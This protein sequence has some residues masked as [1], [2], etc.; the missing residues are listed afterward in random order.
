M[1]HKRG[2]AGQQILPEPRRA[3]AVSPVE[4]GTSAMKLYRIDKLAKQGGAVIKK[5]HILAPT[6]RQAVEEAEQSDD[7][8]I[9]EVL[10]DGRMVGQVL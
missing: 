3:G 4:Q 7:C 9:C 10:R 6:D 8:P 2:A 1:S 5:K